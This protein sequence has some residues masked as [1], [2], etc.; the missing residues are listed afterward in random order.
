MSWAEL[1]PL[2][3]QGTLETLWMVLP[4]ALIAE[5]LGVALGVLLTLTRPG[6]LQANGAV[7]RVLDALIAPDG[8]VAQETARLA[9]L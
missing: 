9:G 3:W 2:L 8:L 1:G 7:F 6:G 4:A 5:V